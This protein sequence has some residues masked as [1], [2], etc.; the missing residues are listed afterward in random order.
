MWS[1]ATRH[2]ERTRATGGRRGGLVFWQFWQWVPGARLIFRAGG[3][4]RRL[5]GVRVSG[6]NVVGGA[7]QDAQGDF[8]LYRPP[9]PQT[10]P[11]R[12]PQC[13]NERRMIRVHAA[14]S[15]SV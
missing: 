1:A 4:R 14:A 6:I 3:A 11:A 2:S 15:E 5:S 9:P 13:L 7:C 10:R 8:G 12:P